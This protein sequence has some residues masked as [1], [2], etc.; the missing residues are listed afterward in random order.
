[1]FSTSAASISAFAIVAAVFVLTPGVGTTYLMQTVLAH[2]RR[3]GYLSAVGMALGAAIHASIAAIGT[4]V[5]L[6]T[7]PRALI[8]IAIVGGAFIIAL[9]GR[10][11]VRALQHRPSAN[12][13]VPRRRAHGIVLTGLLI[14]LS[15]APLPLFYFVVVPQYVPSSMTRVAGV[16]LLSAIHLAMALTW[17]L[18]VVTIVG[19]LSAILRRPRIL[20]T[21]QLVTSLVLITLGASAILDAI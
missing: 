16:T 5:I 20:L 3:S 13:E 14:A 2:G 10:G 9:G 21:A 11:I 6:R 4:A 17:M 15:N 1:M 7:F 8:W 19:R 18:T 12:A